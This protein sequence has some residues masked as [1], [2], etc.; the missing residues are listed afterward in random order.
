MQVYKLR[1][2]KGT[3]TS[4]QLNKQK[5]LPIKAGPVACRVQKVVRL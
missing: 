3:Q 5:M 2:E 1:K 4:E